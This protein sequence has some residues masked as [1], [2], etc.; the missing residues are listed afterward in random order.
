MVRKPEVLSLLVEVRCWVCPYRDF[1]G[2]DGYSSGSDEGNFR[3]NQKVGRGRT[4]ERR[5][6]SE[7]LVYLGRTSE[8]RIQ[9]FRSF[10]RAEESTTCLLSVAAK[11]SN[12][13]LS[14]RFL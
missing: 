4:C 13:T 6:T 7:N 14:A 9:R 5:I 2:D 1:C 8:R 12:P 10:E 3:N 11:S